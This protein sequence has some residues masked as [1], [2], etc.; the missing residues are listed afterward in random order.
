M[1]HWY[2][3]IQLLEY[4]IPPSAAAPAPHPLPKKA[5]YGVS[6][7]YVMVL[8]RVMV[9][10]RVMGLARVMVFTIVMLLTCVMI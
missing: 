9:L 10:T 7:C 3:F 8:A 2:R 5:P 1:C 4:V 6:P